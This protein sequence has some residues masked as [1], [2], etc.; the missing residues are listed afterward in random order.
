MTVRA[1][2]GAV[3]LDRDVAGREA[4]RADERAPRP[5]TGIPERGAPRS[6]I[7][8][9]AGPRGG[10]PAAPRRGVAR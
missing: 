9:A 1:V 4:G 5:L 8:F 6:G 2:R 3:R 10:F 7:R